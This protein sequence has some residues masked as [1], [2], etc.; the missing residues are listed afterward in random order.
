MK[1]KISLFLIALFGSY[2]FE[3]QAQDCSPLI[4]KNILTSYFTV[5]NA[6]VATDNR[7]GL[8]WSRCQY[9]DSIVKGRCTHNDVAKGY[10][11]SEAL[12]IA[13]NSTFSGYS[14]WRVPTIKEMSTIIET[15]CDNPAL[16][17]QVFPTSAIFVWTSTPT[18]ER[19]AFTVALYWDGGFSSFKKEDDRGFFL[20][21]DAS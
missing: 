3:L 8:M 6:E 13:K 17:V 14:G 19:Y 20:V 5:H 12:D 10:S 4:P 16:N 11:W 9:G 15:A 2:A 21:R 7:T 18:Q 1:I